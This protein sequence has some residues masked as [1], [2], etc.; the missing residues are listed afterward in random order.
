MAFNYETCT[1]AAALNDGRQTTV[2]NNHTFNR[3][4]CDLE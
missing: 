2:K 4:S 1:Y 3:Q